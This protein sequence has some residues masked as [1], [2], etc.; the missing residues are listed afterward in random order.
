MAKIRH[1][2]ISSKKWGGWK[3]VKEKKW[4]YLVGQKVNSRPTKWGRVRWFVARGFPGWPGSPQQEARRR[5]ESSEGTTE[6]FELLSLSLS[7]ACERARARS[8]RQQSCR[9][10][11]PILLHSS[12]PARVL[13]SPGKI[14]FYFASFAVISSFFFIVLGTVS[15]GLHVALGNS[16]GCCSGL[17]SSPPPLAALFFFWLRILEMLWS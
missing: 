12:P 9:F 5:K 17:F 4:I 8:F 11:T 7:F 1:R 16:S 3:K 15:W 13:A 14:R 2:K 10:W 6:G